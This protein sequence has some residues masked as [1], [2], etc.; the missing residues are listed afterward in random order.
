[1]A[2]QT[3]CCLALPRTSEALASHY[4]LIDKGRPLAAPPVGGARAGRPSFAHKK[5]PLAGLGS[6]WTRSIAF[7]VRIPPARACKPPRLRRASGKG[8]DTPLRATLLAA[9]GVFGENPLGQ[10]EGTSKKSREGRDAQPKQSQ[11]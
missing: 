3:R 4:A 6:R 2:T 5:G 8:V 7:L 10:P 9:H 11:R 1:M